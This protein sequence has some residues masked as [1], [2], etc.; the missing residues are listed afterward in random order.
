[1]K[2]LFI[3]L[4][5]TTA[6]V[7]TAQGFLQDPFHS[8]YLNPISGQLPFHTAIGH[9]TME[10]GN[11]FVTRN[12]LFWPSA[13][14][15]TQRN[16]QTTFEPDYV[17][18][19]GNGNLSPS[20]LVASSFG[21]LQGEHLFTL[22]GKMNYYNH[23]SLNAYIAKRGFMGDTDQNNDSLT[24]AFS[25][26]AWMG[27]V[28]FYLHFNRWS[29]TINAQG[30]YENSSRGIVSSL[31]DPLPDDSLLYAD[32]ARKILAGKTQL[33]LKYEFRNARF[34]IQSRTDISGFKGEIQ[35]GL[36]QLKGEQLSLNQKFEFRWMVTERLQWKAHAEYIAQ[37][38]QQELD[39]ME[40]DGQPGQVWKMSVNGLYQMPLLKVLPALNMEK[41]GDDKSLF[42]PGLK[43]QLE[44]DEW[45]ASIWYQRVTQM[46]QLLWEQNE[47]LPGAGQWN[48]SAILHPD[49]KQNLNLT[50]RRISS[51]HHVNFNANYAFFEFR[52]VLDYTNFPESIDWKGLHKASKTLQVESNYAYLHEKFSLRFLYRFEKSQVKYGD[53]YELMHFVP[54]HNFISALH[55]YYHRNKDISST[56]SQRLEWN[57]KVSG[58][59]GIAHPEDIQ[60]PNAAVLLHSRMILPFD[61]FRKRE[62]ILS[63]NHQTWTKN[64]HFTLGIENVRLSKQSIQKWY[65]NNSIS[66]LYGPAAF[67]P[68]RVFMGL[69]FAM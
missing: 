44:K 57:V 1:M 50:L 7:S 16:F 31:A 8:V 30:S 45:Y 39:Q 55:L 51:K 66:A 17:L 42:L 25:G 61:F 23:F 52:N 53:E 37:N 48:Y 18:K 49:I 59:F 41:W 9:S 10:L 63:T 15:Y 60:I 68:M 32:F 5:A 40:L 69:R 4:F 28:G 34:K 2:Y 35:S 64:L 36:H 54:Q 11:S 29:A 3:F 21:N 62:F 19:S 38:L 6:F 27:G 43:I 22:A 47:M 12:Y 14:I 65:S 33:D 26:H 67:L 46:Q 24:D 20:K 56:E 13:S 58:H